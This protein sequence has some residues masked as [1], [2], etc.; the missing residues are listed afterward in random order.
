VSVEQPHTTLC[1]LLHP[2]ACCPSFSHRSPMTRR[3]SMHCP[4]VK[5]SASALS[6]RQWCA[7]AGGR[8]RERKLA[9]NTTHLPQTN[10]TREPASIHAL[11][12][13]RGRED[14]RAC[15][16]TLHGNPPAVHTRIS[17]M[18]KRAQRRKTHMDTSTTPHSTS[19]RTQC[20]RCTLLCTTLYLPQTAA[21]SSRCGPCSCRCWSTSAWTSPGGARSPREAQGC[22]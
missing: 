3:R 10:H 11:E 13:S 12:W 19:R 4:L 20:P 14:E 15:N 16:K 17:N 21:R 5:S 9:Y 2:T 6:R 18:C 22:R 1:S 8:G 7:A